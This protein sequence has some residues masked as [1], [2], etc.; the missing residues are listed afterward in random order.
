MRLLGR[1]VRVSGSFEPGALLTQL[2]D[3][4]LPQDKPG[5]RPEA[6][7]EVPFGDIPLLL[8]IRGLSFVTLVVGLTLGLHYYLGVRLISGAQLPEPFAAI[9]WLCLWGAFLSIPLGF[10]LGRLLPRKLAVGVQWVG[11]IWM[12]AFGVMLSATA[13]SDVVLWSAAQAATRTAAWSHLQALTV[14]GLTVPALIIGFRVARRTPT[15]ERLAVTVKGLGKELDG[16]KIVQITDIHIGETLRRDFLE[17]VVSQVNALNPDMVAVT[18]DVIDGSVKSLREEVEPLSRLAGKHGNFY[19]TGNHEYYHGGA[20]WEAEAS[21][22]GL[23]VLHNAHRVLE[24][25]TA[26]LVIAGVPDLDGARFS[27]AH[28][29]D[30]DAAFANAPQGV[31]RILLAHQPRFARRVTGHG[32]ALQLSGHTHGGQ[33]FPFMF[34]VR[35]QQPVIAG[36]KKLWGVPVYTSRGT[37][38]WGPPFRIG[39][40]SEITE[41]TLRCE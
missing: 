39:P 8:F 3:P 4:G 36:F 26:R 5:R 37:G 28:A 25:G 21:R 6:T 27:P 41:I 12:G 35:L 24:Q 16:F 9:A 33:I 15:I 10:I 19:V 40:S 11:F 32:V 14:L 17:R 1:A 22:L 34:F 2:P 31:P 20:A 23:V 29:P 7:E 38:Y 18:G 30:A 13:I